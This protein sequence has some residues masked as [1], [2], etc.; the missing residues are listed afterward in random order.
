MARSGE[1]DDVAERANPGGKHFRFYDT[2]ELRAWCAQRLREKAD[3]EAGQHPFQP[4]RRP[5]VP[6][7]G[8]TPEH[9]RILSSKKL[10]RDPVARNMWTQIAEKKRL[11]PR[12]LQE[13]IRKGIITRIK[14][15]PD[16]NGGYGFASFEGWH[17]QWT[18]LHRQI[19]SAWRKWSVETA[20]EARRFFAPI[21][22]FDHEVEQMIAGRKSGGE[23]NDVA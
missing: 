9:H 19:E 2:P 7:Q 17:F 15:D 22:A 4:R 10:K 16:K 6:W 21:V 13:S 23:R 3:R 14:I 12:E 1:L 5:H 18:I 8:L 11:T 20:E